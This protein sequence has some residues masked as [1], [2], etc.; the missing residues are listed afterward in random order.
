MRISR[1]SRTGAGQE[2]QPGNFA[3]GPKRAAKA[4]RKGGK[5]KHYSHR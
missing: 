3:H 1:L 2:E 4:G 5:T